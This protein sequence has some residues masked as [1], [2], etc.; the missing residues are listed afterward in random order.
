MVLLKIL[1]LLNVL[2]I[3]NPHSGAF[4]LNLNDFS[5]FSNLKELCLDGLH[6]SKMEG[7]ENLTKLEILSLPANDISE[8][9]GINN[10]MNL[11]YLDLSGNKIKEFNKNKLPPNLQELII[12]DNPISYSKELK[13]FIRLSESCDV[14]S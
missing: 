8:I 9:E 13:D 1:N 10:L 6:I 14:R 5:V 11:K 2:L 7:L 12:Y 3:T 4:P